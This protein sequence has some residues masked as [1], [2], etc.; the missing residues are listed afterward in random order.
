MDITTAYELHVDKVYRFFY[1]KTFSRELA[2]DLTSQ[3]FIAVLDKIQDED[4]VI[5]D[6]KKFI[7]G[8]M[9]NIWLQSL[10]E[11]YRRNEQTLEDIENFEDHVV[12]EI[13]EY[14]GLT[15]KQRA[16]VFISC[17]PEQ[18]QKIVRMRLLEDCSIKDICAQT[19]K[20][21]NY[22]KTTYKRGLKRFKQLIME[23]QLP[24]PAG[25]EIV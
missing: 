1:V 3:T 23:Q 4:Y 25:K 10:R 11:K 18:Q 20:D 15:V 22:V 2:E 21:S 12:H 24:Q 19:G 6:H 14:A 13:E 9:R 16:E 7:Y 17:L 8:V 5:G